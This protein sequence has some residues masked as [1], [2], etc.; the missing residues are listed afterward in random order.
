[1]LKTYKQVQKR[2]YDD[3]KRRWVLFQRYISARARSQF[4]LMMSERG[5]TGRLRLEHKNNPP[6]LIIEV[7]ASSQ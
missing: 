3:R 4:M 2:V 6:E 7:R 5:Y 1:M